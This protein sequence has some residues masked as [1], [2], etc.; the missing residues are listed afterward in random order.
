MQMMTSEI[1]RAFK[2]AP[3]YSKDGQGKSAKVIVYFFNPFGRGTWLITEGEKQSNGDWLFYGY[4]HIYNWEW[5]YVTLSQ[6]QSAG[7]VE[8]EMY[9]HPNQYTVAQLLHQLGVHDSKRT[10]T[11]V[12]KKRAKDARNNIADELYNYIMRAYPSAQIDVSDSTGTT[13]LNRDLTHTNTAYNKRVNTQEIHFVI[14]DAEG[15][16][17]FRIMEDVQRF[18]IQKKNDP[19]L[20]HFRIEGPNVWMYITDNITYRDAVDDIKTW[21][22]QTYPDDNVGVGL[23]A[24]IT[25][26]DLWDFL[27]DPAT[28]DVYKF[29]GCSDSVVRERC[30]QQLMRMK[31]VDYDVIYNMWLDKPDR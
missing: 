22:M 3:L 20:V 18:L 15:Q 5:G 8:R 31:N 29:L 4:C 11:Y 14:R 28:G 6:I 2:Q 17:N 7:V 10:T 25:F 30:F 21:Y 27:D 13:T 23:K 1:E 16:I 26:E 9:T 12:V 24:G 19:H